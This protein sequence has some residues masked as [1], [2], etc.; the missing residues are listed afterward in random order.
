MPGPS[1]EC[2]DSK[3]TARAIYV[4]GFIGLALLFIAYTAQVLLLVFAG[5][6]V[7]VVLGKS[8]NAL[9]KR[10]GLSRSLALAAIVATFAAVVL[11]GSLL[12]APQIIEQSRELA[13]ELPKLWR[14]ATSGLGDWLNRDW[15]DEVSEKVQD[16]STGTT[17]DA[18][19]GFLGILAS[20][21]GAIG[22]VLVVIITGLYL[23]ATP[24]LYRDG[25]LRLV[26]KAQRKKASAV[27]DKVG[28]SLLWWMVGKLISM[29]VV[30]L[31]TFVGLWLLGVP[32]ALSLSIVAALLTFIPNFG[33]IL[34][35]IPAVLLG[36][37][38]GATT[39]LYVIGLYVAIQ[40]VESYAITPLIQQRTV[41]LPPALTISAQLIMGVLAGGLG[42]A[43]ATPLAAGILTLVRELYVRDQLE[44]D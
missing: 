9:S 17:S 20:G 34:A 23:A 7:G 27:A 6:L 38:E 26:P 37:S 14:N 32:L 5:V 30:G 19:K 8:A 15:F 43:L 31:L 12:L 42:L 40:T 33:P 29:V 28:E 35:A 1:E 21:L 39:G 24:N 10:S 36:F 41:S 25:A 16:P 11:A 2:E 18:L 4:M 44:R 22:S 13:A 3:E